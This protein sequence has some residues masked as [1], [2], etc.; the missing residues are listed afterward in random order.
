MNEAALFN[1][2]D[3]RDQYL[4]LYIRYSQIANEYH[5]VDNWFAFGLYKSLVPI[6]RDQFDDSIQ[7]QIAREAYDR[8]LVKGFDHNKLADALEVSAGHSD[9]A[10]Y[11][12]PTLA[13]RFMPGGLQLSQAVRHPLH[14]GGTG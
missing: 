12:D 11:T 5:N 6:A 10:L 4:A 1:D 8:L 9:E 3:D 2:D 7:G 13:S 14:S